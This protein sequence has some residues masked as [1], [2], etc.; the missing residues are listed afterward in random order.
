MTKPQ[1]ITKLKEIAAMDLDELRMFN[2]TLSIS[3]LE[4]RLKKPMLTVCDARMAQLMEMT[5]VSPMAII[6]EIR[7]GGES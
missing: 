4:S 5:T 3:N 6:S 2:C 1:M 7:E